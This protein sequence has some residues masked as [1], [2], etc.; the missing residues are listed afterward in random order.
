[1]EIAEKLVGY[2]KE[3]GLQIAVAESCTG[4]LLA[5]ALVD[6]PGASQVFEEG[7]V[8]YSDYAKRKNLGVTAETLEN[9]TAVSCPTAEEMAEGL[10]KK[11][12][13]GVTVATTGYAGP[14]PGEDGTPAGTVYIGVCYKEHAQGYHLRLEGSRNEVRSKA[15]EEA[16]SLVMETLQSEGI[17]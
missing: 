12:R 14:E 16:L 1:M 9:Y 6:V 17:S 2:L 8:T 15:V 4:G 5:S 13:V 7:F 10:M 11:T 3:H